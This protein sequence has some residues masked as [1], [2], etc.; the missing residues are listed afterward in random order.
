M[1]AI[2]FDLSTDI[3]KKTYKNDSIANAYTDIKCV[4]DS[5]GFKRQQG[6]VYFGS[7]TSNAVTCFEAVAEL[8]ERFDW[9]QPSVQDIRMLHIQDDNDLMP[10]ITRI[11]KGRHK[12]D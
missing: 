12:A 10:V 1:F 11:L 3:L 7:E 2:A 5:F 6:S 8:T 9:F 4:L